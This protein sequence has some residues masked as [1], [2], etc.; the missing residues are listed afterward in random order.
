MWESLGERL[1]PANL[2]GGAARS[3][4]LGAGIYKRKVPRQ[5]TLGRT[6]IVYQEV[7]TKASREE[8]CL[9]IKA[10]LLSTHTFEH[11]Y[12]ESTSTHVWFVEKTE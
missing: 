11:I 4:D 7:G 12:P 1:A 10:D 8:H 3:A 6:V 5:H 9:Y 2:H